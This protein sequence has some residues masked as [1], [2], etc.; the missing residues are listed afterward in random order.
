MKFLFA[1]ILFS[2]LSGLLPNPAVGQT[3]STFDVVSVTGTLTIVGTSTFKSVLELTNSSITLTGVNGH[4]LTS[5]GTIYSSTFSAVPGSGNSVILRAMDNSGSGI[6]GSITLEAG[7]AGSSNIGGSIHLRAG[8]GTSG[9]GGTVNITAGTGGNVGGDINLRAGDETVNGNHLA[10]DVNIVGG[11]AVAP[12]NSPGN[13]FLS[14]G[15]DGTNVAAVVLVA[16]APLV[17]SGSGGAMTLESSV[18]ASGFFGA[19][20]NLG[21]RFIIATS[22]LVVEAG[23]VGIGTAAPQ[24]PLDV[25]GAAQFGTSVT[26]S[27]FTATPG[28]ATYALQLSSGISLAG[29][30]PV[31]LTS[32]GYI[33]FADGTIMTSTAGFGGGAGS[34][35][36]VSTRVTGTESTTSTSWL[37][38]TGATVSLTMSGR[39]A[40]MRFNC[41]IAGISAGGPCH[42]GFL[43]NG[44]Y[45]DGET[46]S[47]GFGHAVAQDNGNTRASSAGG[48]DG[49]AH[50]TESTYTG[51]TT[52]APIYKSGSAGG[53]A[54]HVNSPATTLDANPQVICQFTVIELGN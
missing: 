37:T 36:F 29:G 27:T 50:T 31:N 44:A 42:T 46:A 53:Y 12:G 52:F 38:V 24:L 16:N 45:I 21:Q 9:P 54:C 51:S 22:T 47:L 40:E 48:G 14:P 33:R 17:L 19:S 13:V 34:L 26:K 49:W 7:L 6:G 25:N 41:S 30:G 23:R 3:V 8:N 1:V 35:A 10:G 4:I 20:A 43:V 18:T 11:N 5:S 39:R 15:N 32:G 2:Y 28:G